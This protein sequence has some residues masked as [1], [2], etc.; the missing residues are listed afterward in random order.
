V[1]ILLALGAVVV[2]SREP[3]P[4]R[5]GRNVSLISPVARLAGVMAFLVAMG[6]I[7]LVV[8]WISY[9]FYSSISPD[10]AVEPDWNLMP[11][12][13]PVGRAVDLARRTRL[14]P[15]TY[16]FGFL[17]FADAADNRSAFLLGRHSDRGW[18]YYFP[19]TFIIKTPIALMALLALSVALGFGKPRSWRRERFLWLPVLIYA[20]IAISVALNIGHRHLLPIYPFLFVAAGGAAALGHAARRSVATLSVVA[21]LAGWY[22]FSAFRI[23]P[24]YLAYFNELVGGPERGYRYLVDSNLDWGQDL[25]GLKAYMDRHGIARIKLSYF[26][27]ADPDYYGIACD[28]LPGFPE[29]ERIVTEVHPGDLLAVSATNL[30]GLNLEHGRRLMSRLRERQPIDTIG[31][32]ILVFRSDFDWSLE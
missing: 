22:A 7:A 32:S 23:H 29:P 2:L 24:H 6:A 1:P 12:G 11:P 26:G 5:F 9:G 3:I 15:E 10:P 4:V 19:V 18:W 20:L 14:L 16:L 21:I 27:T 28:R 17:A 31:Y 30:Q 25:K 13:H 8:V